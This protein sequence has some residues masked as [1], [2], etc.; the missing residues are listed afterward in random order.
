MAAK[1]LSHLQQLEAESI[2]I[3]REVAAE[4]DNPVMMYSIGKDSSV[5]LHLARK[6]FYPGKIPFPL[7][8]VDTDW[9]FKEMIAFRDAQAKEFGFELLVHKNPDGIAMGVGPF[10]HGSAK[11]TDIMKTQGLK[12]AL[13]KYG[14]D[15]AF[16]GARRD[17]EKSRA[18]ERVYSFR[19]KHHTWDPKNQRPELW[20]TYNGAVNKGESIRVFPLSNWTE[21]DI[22][23]YI[24]QENIKLVPLYFAQKRPVVERDGMMIMV[25]DDRLPLEEGETVKN[26]LVR[27]RTLG[28]YPLTGAMHSE[29]DTLE[30]IIEEMLLTRSSE[31]EGRLI[32]SDQ[33][34]SME[35]KKRQGYF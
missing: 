30:K 34:A 15:A 25:D 32:D 18:K 31:R 6:A 2:Q 4:F 14:F 35:L 27:F 28:C 1:E 17:E 11:H 21:L 20:R 16:G 24:Y 19:D 23:Q 8:H 7:L 5:M 13:N 12:Q 22:W 3:I 9:K 10:T 26:E 29:A 33:S